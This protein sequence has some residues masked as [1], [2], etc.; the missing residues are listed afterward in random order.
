MA[1]IERHVEP[2][3]FDLLHHLVKNGDKVST[4]D[5]LIN[6]VWKGRVVSDSAFNVRI[7]AARKVLGDSGARQDIIKTVPRKGFRRNH[8][9]RSPGLRHDRVIQQRS[10]RGVSCRQRGMGSRVDSK[11]PAGRKSHQKRS[12]PIPFMSE[13]VKTFE[14]STCH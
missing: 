7:N 4:Y 6:T 5:E 2:Q 13:P 12:D 8:V 14:N 9:T 10:G 1:G 11:R 3:V